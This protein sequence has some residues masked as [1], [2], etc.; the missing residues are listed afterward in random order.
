MH[1]FNE[2]SVLFDNYTCLFTL[3]RKS[4]DLGIRSRQGMLQLLQ[5]Q[6]VNAIIIQVIHSPLATIITLFWWLH[7]IY[8]TQQLYQFTKGLSSGWFRLF[9][10]VRNRTGKTDKYFDM[11]W[12]RILI[13]L[14]PLRSSSLTFYNVERW[15][16]HRTNLIDSIHGR[17]AFC[18]FGL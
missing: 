18:D 4:G 1:C 12:W 13:L 10:M 7:H 8:H 17:L 5:I 16:S 9:V 2:T 14:F 11:C 6:I 3:N 15:S